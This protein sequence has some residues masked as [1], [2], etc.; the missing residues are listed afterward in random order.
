MLSWL[1]RA[2]ALG[3][4]AEAAERFFVGRLVA[5]EDLDGHLAVER[6]VVGPKDDAHTAAADEFLQ[7]ELAQ[8]LPFPLA[9]VLNGRL[10]AKFQIGCR[11]ASRNHRLLVV[12][13]ERG[14]GRTVGRAYRWQL[15]GLIPREPA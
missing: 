2:A 11:R 15:R 4:V 13:R 14:P 5:R 8:L 3:L 1:S 7:H 6:R 12:R 10:I 9:A